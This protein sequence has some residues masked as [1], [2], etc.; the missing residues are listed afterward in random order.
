[1]TDPVHWHALPAAAVLDRL[2]SDP[3]G[4]TEQEGAVRLARYGPNVFRVA[5]PV[6]AWVILL[7]QFRSVMIVLLL[8]VT[9]TRLQILPTDISPSWCKGSH[10]YRR[11]LS[12]GACS[13][14]ELRRARLGP[15]PR[16]LNQLGEPLGDLAFQLRQR[17]ERAGMHDLLDPARQ[18]RPD[19]RKLGEA[20]PVTVRDQLLDR[21]RQLLDGPS[22]AL[23]GMF[24][25][26]ATTLLRRAWCARRC[27]TRGGRWKLQ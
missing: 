11:N 12:L 16:T 23:V 24:A 7:R 19:A 8:A 14:R 2:A 25:S 5:R 10:A 21:P 17:G 3:L 26:P 6:S 18:I 4:L 1:M 22:G 27:N 9:T 20:L 15:S 13:E